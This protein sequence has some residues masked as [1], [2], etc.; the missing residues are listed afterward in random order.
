MADVAKKLKATSIIKIKYKAAVL[1][2]V[3]MISL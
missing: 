2:I 1:V 3:M